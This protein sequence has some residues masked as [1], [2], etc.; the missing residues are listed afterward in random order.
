[1]N[2]KLRLLFTENCN[3]SCEMCCNKE[4][5][6]DTLP[7]VSH[8]NYDEILITGGEP[9]LYLDKLV[10]LIIEIK[11]KS[12]AKVYVYTAMIDYE[13]LVLIADVDGITLTLHTQKDVNDF[14]VFQKTIIRC[15]LYKGKSL[16]LVIFKGLDARI[17]NV[18]HWD[19][20]DNV[21][22]VNDC[23]IPTGEDFKRL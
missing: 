21:E 23:P 2:K 22:W 12:N 1:M 16:R 14:A 3:R 20:T 17:L 6:L 7:K 11:A 9:L 10:L 18:D 4:Y 15:K 8:Y 13:L 5:N 19:V